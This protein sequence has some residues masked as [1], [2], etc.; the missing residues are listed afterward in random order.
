[1]SNLES[2]SHGWRGPRTGF[3]GLDAADQA[4]HVLTECVSLLVRLV[5]DEMV[6]LGP[7]TLK[8]IGSA[9][10]EIKSCVPVLA[11][12][13]GDLQP[14]ADW[15]LEPPFRRVGVNLAASDAFVDIENVERLRRSLDLLAPRAL[16]LRKEPAIVV[17]DALLYE[18]KRQRKSEP[19]EGRERR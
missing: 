4:F 2:Q 10:D 5:T 15:V 1:M 12:W 14:S 19:I 16:A 3:D 9:A 13:K 6:P 17:L 7:S 8:A 11:A 18:I